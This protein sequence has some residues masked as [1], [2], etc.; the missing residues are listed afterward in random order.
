MNILHIA[1]IHGNTSSIDN[2]KE[3]IPQVDLIIV[4]GDITHFGEG[5]SAANIINCYKAFHLP[6]LAVSGNCDQP[7]VEEYLIREKISLHRTFVK[8]GDLSLVGVG[9]SL[10]CPG[11][12]PC[13]Y[14]DSLFGEWLEETYHKA[15]SPPSFIL[16][17]H[18]P[19]YG[20]TADLTIQLL[21]VG[22]RSIRNFIEKHQPLL[23]LCGHIHEAAGTDQLGSTYI[24]NPGAFKNGHYATIQ[25]NRQVGQIHII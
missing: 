1:D 24:V 19:P 12:T 2:L 17:T 5:E 16:V 14:P 9:G 4:S 13:E 20:T 7:G 3:I 18:Q 21:H 23:C 11:K 25:V 22:C 10:P 15:G 6:L 8:A